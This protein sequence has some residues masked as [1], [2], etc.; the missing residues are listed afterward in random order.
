MKK[1]KLFTVLLFLALSTYTFAQTMECE[2]VYLQTDKQLYMAGELMWMKLYTTDDSG[3]LLS[4]S[5]VGYVELV[6]DSVPEAQVKIEITEGTGAGW[7]ELSPM[8]PTGYYRLVAYTRYMRNEGEPVFFEKTIGIINPYIRNERSFQEEDTGKSILGTTASTKPKA[9]QGLITTD[10]SHYSK[11][12][13]GELTI[14]GIPAENLSLGISIAGTDP[15][16]VSPSGISDWK[17][18]IPE[19]RTLQMPDQLLLPEYEGHILEGKLISLDS[20]QPEN[21]PTVTGL[22]SFPGKNIQIYGNKPDAEGNLSFY[23]NRLAGKTELATVAVNPYEKQYRID[24]SSPFVTHPRQELPPLKIDSAWHDYV[25]NRSLGVQVTEA[26][27]ADKLS[28]IAPVLPYF[29]YKPYREY[30]LDEY[31]RFNYM[32]EL[33]IEFVVATRIRKTGK[34]KEFNTMTE[35]LS[36]YSFGGALVL[37]D[38]IPVSNHELMVAYNPLL[39]K[40][41]EIYLGR[42]LF[43]GTLFD[44]IVSFS[45]YNYNYPGITFDANTQL[46]DYEGTQAYRYFYAP[47]YDTEEHS[48]RMP[49]FRHTLLWEPSLRSEGRTEITIPFY[50][51]DLPG[52]YIVTVEGISK[53]GTVISAMH[54]FVVE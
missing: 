31:T 46:F 22:L 35:D 5:K 11:R 48:P 54:E 8:L 38:N 30:L 51:S 10:R 26:Y 4:F 42:Y 43:G 2:R 13:K 21:A 15:L 45:T 25:A 41:I 37:L 27:T 36:T 33:F 24:I 47:A 16:F 29:N 34:G 40:K 20:N 6:S 19:K 49:D 12:A 44:G 7:I 39:I 3:S 50:T 17:K 1:Y 14:K 18:N 53:E 32:E 52:S 9:N 23:T 28:R